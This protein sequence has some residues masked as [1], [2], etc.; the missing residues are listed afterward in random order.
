[1]IEVELLI[2]KDLIRLLPAQLRSDSLYR[3]GHFVVYR[4]LT[5]R[6]SVKDVIEALGIPHCEVGTIGDQNEDPIVL[7]TL[8]QN[9]DQLTLD[10]TGPSNLTTPTFLCDQHLGRLARL[11]RIMG[12]DTTWDKHWLEPEIARRAINENRTVLSRSRSLLKRKTMNQAQLIRSDDPDQQAQ[13][14][15]RRWQLARQIRFLGRCSLCNG[16]LSEVPKATVA[17]RIPPKT[18]K[19]LD[20]YYVCRECDQL[21]WEGTH[22]LTL[23]RRIANITAQITHP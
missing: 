14:V 17:D 21:Y 7:N 19:W 2:P 3:N 16:Q 10:P 12:F 6:A 13:E 1:M 8:V 15:L 4:R 22:V 20:T 9:G 23:R 11:L 18:A 5:A